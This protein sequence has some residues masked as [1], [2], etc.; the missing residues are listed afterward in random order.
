MESDLTASPVS[1]FKDRIHFSDQW[2]GFLTWQGVTITA[3]SYFTGDVRKS[4]W[5]L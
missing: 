5:K 2:I 4:A 1:F 3:A